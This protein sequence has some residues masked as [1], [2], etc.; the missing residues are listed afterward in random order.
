MPCTAPARGIRQAPPHGSKLLF[1]DAINNNPCGK[2]VVQSVGG[3][4]VASENLCSFHW[5]FFH[6]G[7]GFVGPF[8]YE[9]GGGAALPPPPALT[10]TGGVITDAIRA[11]GV[12][13]DGR[14]AD[15]SMGIWDA[16]TNLLL[17]GGFETNIAGWTG[18]NTGL[19]TRVTSGSKFGSACAQVVTVGATQGIE[20]SPPWPSVTPSTPYTA[21][22]WVFC[23]AGGQAQMGLADFTTVS[24][25]TNLSFPRGP[26]VTVP[27]GVWTRLTQTMTVGATAAG[28]DCICEF[29]PGTWLVD[30][31]QLEQKAVATPY[32]H[33]DGATATRA[34][35]KVAVPASLF[36]NSLG[37]A[38]IRA[39]MGFAYAARPGGNH[40]PF[41]WG[42]SDSA[43]I[44]LIFTTG[45]GLEESFKVNGSAATA[46]HAFGPAVGDLATLLVA[47]D[48]AN[49]KNSLDG[50]TFGTAVAPATAITNPLAYLA[51]WDG[52]GT[53]YGDILAAAFGNGALSNAD[54]A[55]IQAFLLANDSIT[56]RS[57]IH[58]SCT[59]YYDMKT[60]TG[61]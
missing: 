14:S 24:G 56:D 23:A 34:Q 28:L 40:Y 6:G 27:A 36:G 10:L 31:W 33:T 30:G 17:N 61:V 52:N 7:Q 44:G 57:L 3:V 43:R 46:N 1:N 20:T 55:A 54:A 50:S 19:P 22:V 15:S 47:W 60:A 38:C 39:R 37:W 16:T 53:P 25:G 42:D 32:V 29:T 26:L 58:S 12:E 4:N 11:A 21:S 41:A 51:H 48:A 18:R 45:S 49:V 5:Q 9:A 8:V 35:G 2:P 13:G 59:G